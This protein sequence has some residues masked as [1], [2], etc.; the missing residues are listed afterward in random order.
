M[1][2]LCPFRLIE[3]S[4]VRV[5]YWVKVDY[6]VSSC[7]SRGKFRVRHQVRIEISFFML[8][9][10][11]FRLWMLITLNLRAWGQFPCGVFSIKC[12]SNICRISLYN[13]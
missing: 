11:T 1:L 6:M 10:F 2:G 8:N 5:K 4:K 7:Q 9:R 3:S 13:G 12:K